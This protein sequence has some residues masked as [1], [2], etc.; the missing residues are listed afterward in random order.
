MELEV[1]H[2][3]LEA[4]RL[5]FEVVGLEARP[6]ELEVRYVGLEA[7]RLE[8]VVQRDGSLAGTLWR[9]PVNARSQTPLCSTHW[10]LWGRPGSP[11]GC[12]EALS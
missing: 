12:S 9:A 7:R 11:H 4:R 2:V 8:L 5:E 10:L 6:L 3:G 1:R